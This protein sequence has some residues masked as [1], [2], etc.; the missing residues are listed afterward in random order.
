[1]GASSLAF[2]AYPSS[3]HAHTKVGKIEAFS[4]N[5]TAVTKMAPAMTNRAYPIRLSVATERRNSSQNS[6]K[7]FFMI[8]I[9]NRQARFDQSSIDWWERMVMRFMGD[10]PIV[11]S[12]FV[13]G[14]RVQLQQILKQRTHPIPIVFMFCTHTLKSIRFGMTTMLESAN[15]ENRI[16]WMMIR[17]FM[18]P[19]LKSEWDEQ[20]LSWVFIRGTRIFWLY[21]NR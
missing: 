20:V 21:F 5:K 10:L 15:N 19:A 14:L 12:Q 3:I 2:S 17:C 13:H 16:N 8:N 4:S 1:M 18:P 11:H 9:T 7:S 6:S